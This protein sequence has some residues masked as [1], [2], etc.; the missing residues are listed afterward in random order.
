RDLVRGALRDLRVVL[1][2]RRA[3]HL[4]SALTSSRTEEQDGRYKDIY[5]D[6]LL[7]EA[8]SYYKLER[9]NSK[10][11]FPRGAKDR[12][13]IP[14]DATAAFIDLTSYLLASR[15]P[16]PQAIREVAARISA[17]LDGEPGLEQFTPDHIAGMLAGFTCRK[18]L[19]RWLLRRVRPRY[20]F[21]CDG[22]G[23]H[24]LIAAARECEVE[25]C[26]FQHGIAFAGG[27]EYTWPAAASAYQ[28]RMPIPDR[29]F[30]YGEHWRQMLDATGFWGDRLRVT[31]SPRMDQ[32]RKI[33]ASRRHGRG[34]SHPLSLVL[35]TQG[36]ET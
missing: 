21:S 20:V 33:Q 7:L 22:Y 34:A 16:P 17:C 36:I 4:V 35:T 8:G 32:Y 15:T 18:R 5:F 2:P 27:P 26:E 1:W 13:L 31:G 10:Q 29:I 24:D 25:V 3:R 6:D 23:E 11:L 12:A 30:L 14:S 19:Y 28:D 9:I